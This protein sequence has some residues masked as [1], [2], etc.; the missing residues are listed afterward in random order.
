MSGLVGSSQYFFGDTGFY[1]Y[2]IGQSCRFESSANERLSRSVSSSG[3]RKTFTWSCWIKR[4][5]TTSCALFN[6]GTSATEI[7]Q[8]M[9]Q[10]DDNLRFRDRTGGD[11]LRKDTTALLRDVS[12]WYHL[13]CAVD[14]TQASNGDRVKLYINGTLQTDFSTND[15]FV[16]RNTYINSSGDDMVVGERAY[17]TASSCSG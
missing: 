12:A 10:G 3:N 2:E 1:P 15:T 4:T 11:N 14:L 5:D 9:I 8:F 17:D 16:N 6:S 7:T 13:V